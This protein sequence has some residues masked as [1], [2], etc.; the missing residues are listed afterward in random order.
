MRIGTLVL[1]VFVIIYVVFQLVNFSGQDYTYYTV[2]SQTV[3]DNLSVTGMFFREE[4]TIPIQNGGIV[5]YEYE[6]GEK[7]SSSARVASIY[8]NQ[9]A[10][11]RQ[12]EMKNLQET[13]QSLEK[14]QLGSQ[15]T[16]AIR[17]ETLNGMISEYTARLIA[18]RDKDDYSGLSSYRTALSEVFARREIIINAD[19]DYTDE[20]ASIRTRLEEL[21]AQGG[22]SSSAVYTDVSGYFVDY[23]DGYEGIATLEALSTLTASGMDQMLADYPGDKV[24]TSSVRIVTSQKWWY[25]ASVSEEQARSIREGSTVTIRFPNLENTVQA[26]VQELRRE[27]ETGNFLVILQG[28]TILPYLLESRVQA[29]EILVQTYTG[30]KVPKEAIRFNEEGQMGV[31]AVLMGKMYFRAVGQIYESDSFIISSTSYESADGS[32]TLKLYDTI[33]LGG[34]GLYDQKPVS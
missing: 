3:E 6:V 9:A 8:Q 32:P 27:E 28:D 11:D 10:V 16:D 20:I 22:E 26:V 13:L 5:S 18:S 7:I 33:I 24:D 14:A 34:V 23:V 29:T 17:P 21:E 1:S 31:Y 19:V 4:S 2:Y 15:T 25:A 12:R 30:L